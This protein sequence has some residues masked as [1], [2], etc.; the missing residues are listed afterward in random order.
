M[1]EMQSDLARHARLSKASIEAQ[2]DP[3]S[4]GKQ[5]TLHEKITD[6][7]TRSTRPKR[8][9]L[10]LKIISV[11]CAVTF[12]LTSDMTSTP[13]ALTALKSSQ[14]IENNTE[15]QLVNSFNAA[16]PDDVA[17]VT[18]TIGGQTFTRNLTAAEI[19]AFR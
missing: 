17:T 10:W 4:Y 11:I 3:F 13:T 19:N 5:K 1:V 8:R 7:H 12:Y 14:N 2:Q 6:L 9:F 16:Q 15:Q 18:V